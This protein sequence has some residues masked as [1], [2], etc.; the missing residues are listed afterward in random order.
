MDE[1]LALYTREAARMVGFEG[2]G[3]IRAGY[4]ASFVMLDRDILD[5]PPDE[6]DQI[7]V[8]RTYIRGR[9]AFEQRD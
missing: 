2:L 8:A 6:I 9:L 3:V 1:A 7:R 4:K 5:T